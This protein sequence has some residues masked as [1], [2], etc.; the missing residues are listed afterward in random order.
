LQWNETWSVH[1]TTK[2]GEPSF[3]LWAAEKRPDRRDPFLLY[4]TQYAVRRIALSGPAYCRT[5]SIFTAEASDQT[6]FRRQRLVLLFHAKR[7]R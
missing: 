3:I 5:L 4:D 7:V 2:Q 6:A 1:E